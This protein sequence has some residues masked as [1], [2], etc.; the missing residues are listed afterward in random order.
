MTRCKCGK[1]GDGGTCATSTQ[2]PV[3][4][5][6]SASPIASQCNKIICADCHNLGRCFS[7]LLGKDANE[8]AS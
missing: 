5:G 2:T 8:T 1:A 7:P 6:V 3:D 4:D